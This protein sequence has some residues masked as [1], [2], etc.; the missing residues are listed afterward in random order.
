MLKTSFCIKK[1]L[2]INPIFCFLLTQTPFFPLFLPRSHYPTVEHSGLQKDYAM[3]DETKKESRR[4]CRM[5]KKKYFCS[6]VL[7]DDVGFSV[8][9]S[10]SPPRTK[11]RRRCQLVF[12]ARF[13]PPISDD[14][15]L[16]FPWPIR[17]NRG[18][19]SPRP[20]WTV[21][22]RA[23]RSAPESAGW[24]TTRSATPDAPGTRA[25]G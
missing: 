3:P 21:P 1:I 12:R 24:V 9:T 11:P 8:T 7:I 13:R 16:D 20:T 18:Y 23:P 22:T 15:S 2:L 25:V 19:R 17:E 6:L 14:F 5:A 4:K 10:I